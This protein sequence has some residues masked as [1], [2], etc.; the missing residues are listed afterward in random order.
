MIQLNLIFKA[1]QNHFNYT[2]EYSIKI[3][4][5]IIS[6]FNAIEFEN[7]LKDEVMSIFFSKHLKSIAGICTFLNSKKFIGK[8]SPVLLDKLVLPHLYPSFSKQY[9]P[10]ITTSD[11]NCLWNMISIGIC[12]NESLMK[13]LRFLTVIGILLFKKDLFKLMETRYRNIDQKI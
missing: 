11:G 10:F 8:V 7:I 5:S 2:F 6:E 13:S 12:G 9:E 4:E 3:L 1:F